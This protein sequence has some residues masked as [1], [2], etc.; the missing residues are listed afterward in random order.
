ME[1]FD[2]HFVH[3]GKVLLVSGVKGIASMNYTNV[4]E[5][6]LMSPRVR[7]NVLQGEGH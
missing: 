3:F 5:A 1:L 4:P 7:D 6:E 2:T